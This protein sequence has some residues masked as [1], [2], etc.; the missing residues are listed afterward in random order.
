MLQLKLI[1][2][3]PGAGKTTLARKYVTLQGYVH[4]EPDQFFYKNG[5]YAYDSSKRNEATKWARNQVYEALLAGRNVVVSDNFIRKSSVEPYRRLASHLK[6]NLEIITLKTQFESPHIKNK[7][8][9][10]QIKSQWEEIPE[11]VQV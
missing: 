3:L 1:R 7:A 9:L 6:A 4:I 2:G 10:E 8:M 5:R 11:D